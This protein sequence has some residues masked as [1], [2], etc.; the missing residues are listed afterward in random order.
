MTRSATM[1]STI[2]RVSRNTRMRGGQPRPT[3]AST[4]NANAVS[5]PITMPQPRAPG[6]PSGER[7][8]DQ[9]G[10]DHPADRRD[11]RRREAP[12]LAQLPHVELTADLEPDHEEEERHQPVVDPVEQVERQ[13]V[14]PERD[15][16]VRV[17]ELLVA[18]APRVSSPR[19]ARP[20][21]AREQDDRRSRSGS[22]RTHGT[23]PPPAS[24]GSGL[25][26][27]SPRASAGRC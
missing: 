2:T 24:A 16:Q 12:A 23:A 14:V 21:V 7:E 3:S 18:G 5:V 13:L 15:R 22:R 17:P 27:R 9:R 26:R 20:T 1:S 4:P 19:P 25:R 8:V 11:D 6:V 10:D